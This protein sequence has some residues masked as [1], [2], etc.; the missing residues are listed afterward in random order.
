M[1]PGK[2][3][4]IITSPILSWRGK[5]RLAYERFIKQNVEPGDESVASF[6]RRRLGQEAF[7]RL[8]Q[9]LVGGIYTGDPEKLSLAATLP[10]FLEM[11]RKYGSLTR[12]MRMA[13]SQRSGVRSQIAPGSAGGSDSGARYSLFVAPCDG[14]SSFVEAIAARLPNGCVVLNAP[15]ERLES[16]GGQWSVVS[17]QCADSKLFDAVI[18][19]T[20]APIAAKL[21]G[22]VAH[23]V[24]GELSQIEHAGTVIV[25]LG[26]ERSQIGHPLDSFGFVVPA[27]E[28]R[29]ILSAS[30]SS[31]K[32]HGRAPDGKVLIRA[33]LGGALQ[34]DMLELR[35]DELCR[36]AEE[37]LRDLLGISGSPCLS[38]AFR[39]PAVMPQYHVGHLERLARINSAIAKLPGLALAGN[40]YEGVGIPQCIKSG[41]SAAER[42]IGQLAS[43]L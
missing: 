9:P 1:A 21:L 42:V 13:R 23:D 3:W 25:V 31:V 27:V 5:A 32:F 22:S 14:L 19:A 34:P 28:R 15:I 26:Y 38:L 6:A 41:E 7:E 24:A 20:P 2:V 18:V 43:R 33:F 8:V 4:P 16:R 37:E 11:E 30:F 12:A 10:R 29:R 40:A 39:W 36:I 35:D 17:G